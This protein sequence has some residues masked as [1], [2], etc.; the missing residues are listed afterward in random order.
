MLLSGFLCWNVMIDSYASIYNCSR[1]F[2]EKNNVLL[3]DEEVLAKIAF[4]WHHVSS[5]REERDH[6]VLDFVLRLNMEKICANIR[7][8]SL[9]TLIE[10]YFTDVRAI[11]EQFRTSM[12]NQALSLLENFLDPKHF[13]NW[14]S[15]YQ[16]REIIE[17]LKGALKDFQ[18]KSLLFNQ[19]ITSEYERLKFKEAISF[20]EASFLTEQL[21]QLKCDIS[22]LLS[23]P[24]E[25]IE[26][27]LKATDWN[28]PQK[29]HGRKAQ[30]NL[31]LRLDTAEIP[32]IFDI[33]L[34]LPQENPQPAPLVIANETP[35][36]SSH[37]TEVKEPS[38]PKNK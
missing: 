38:P 13:M 30:R 24:F 19:K 15:L 22:S 12:N 1:S 17:P 36:P 7:Q 11:H 25:L 33:K 9:I 5:A 3:V 6:R 27:F 4:C 21:N 18:A 35:E 31:E 37:L 8:P 29:G 16:L 23:N 14:Q 2:I 26:L 10:D 20:Q 32:W 34:K 28:L